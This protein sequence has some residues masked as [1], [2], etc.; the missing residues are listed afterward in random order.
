MRRSVKYNI[1]FMLCCLLWF[2]QGSAEEQTQEQI[3]VTDL[4]EDFKEDPRGPYQAI[5]WFCPDG[6][7]IPAQERCDQPGGIQHALHKDVA[8]KLAEEHG[9]YLGQ[10][11]AGTDFEEF[12][13]AANR[14]SRAKQYQMEQFLQAV[15][16]G[17]IMRKARYYRGAVQVEDEEAWGREFLTWLVARDDVLQS[18]F[19]LIR[20]LVK[21]IPHQANNDRATLIRALSQTIADSLDLFM[22]IR[23]KIHAKPDE[24]D[25]AKVREFRKVYAETFTPGIDKQLLHLEHQLRA[26]YKEANLASLQGYL[27]TFPI[28]TPVGAQLNNVLKYHADSESGGAPARNGFDGVKNK[29]K[30]CEEIAKL[31][32]ILRTNLSKESSPENRLL[33]LDLSLEAESIV[34]KNINQYKPETVEG[35]LHKGYIL[36]KA[37]AG[38]GYVEEWEW[39]NIEPI[40]L[41][42]KTTEALRFERF[43]E[44]ASS[45]RREVDWGTSMVRA[46]YEPVV[47]LFAEFEPL[48]HG[49][50]DDRIRSSVL[51]PFGEVCGQLLEFA[52]SKSGLR[53]QV[54]DV[55]Q[56]TQV[57]GLNPGFAV[58]V[59][60]VIEGT[61]EKID[62]STEKIYVIQR[63]P[64]E[65]K[66]V[67][68]IATVTEGNTVSHVQLLARNLGIPNAVVSSE[69]LHQ[70][71]KYTQTEVFYAVS[72]R[73]SV[74]MKP[75]GEMTE[76]ERTLVTEKQRSE[77]RV[78]VPTEK[79]DLEQREIISLFDLRARH[80]G[81]ICGPKAANL[82]QLSAMFPGKVVPG[83]VLPFGIFRAHLD[84]PMPG[85]DITYWD[86]LQQAFA[87]AEKQHKQ[88]VAEDRIE[89]QLLQHFETFRNAIEEIPF[90]P[91]FVAELKQRFEQEFKAEMG[92]LPIFIRSDTNM[93]DL[94]DFVG[95]G[96]NK[97]AINIL[98]E[99]EILSSIK[100]VWASPYSDRSFRWRQK[101]L[102][103]P[104][105]V[106]PSL[107][108]MPS[109]NVEKSGV[110]ITTGIETGNAHDITVAMNW[111][112][113][114]A[115]MGQTTET[116]LFKEDGT[117]ILLSPAR[118]TTYNYLP[119]KGGISQPTVTFEK[120]I[121]NSAERQKL[122][123]FAEELKQKLPRT[124]GIETEGP[125]DVE[126]GFWNDQ[127]WLFQVRPFV[128]N[129]LAQSSAYLTSLDP[130]RPENLKIKLTEKM[131]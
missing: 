40:L 46:I 10:I 68:G 72:P 99:E 102:L 100:E 80:S 122:R 111:G 21:D 11:L 73:G 131:E 12:W 98:Q 114:G 39:L 113:A 87:E 124:P 16:N 78:M 120:P 104:E 84:Q 35:L 47:A 127:I 62:F 48:A 50:I 89:N 22:D 34:F 30:M 53:N 75:V 60:E 108:L 109:V 20:Q 69:V 31:L 130:A 3:K 38:C 25:L 8:M 82:G 33:M 67:A 37:A 57:R 90:L 42:S 81:S 29:G 88:G 2:G 51:L 128:E 66:P 76:V 64:S 70:L 5:R 79:L 14:H 96:L 71:E 6:S 129:K 7:V 105:N 106:F 83:L 126:L 94:K 123:L 26:Y 44:I 9:I 125:F 23:V 103:N 24:T 65:M 36:A 28:H 13:D 91:G 110:M 101:Y 32:W 59:L 55:K 77:E 41:R 97:S 112:G 121:L 85:K 18:H 86:F 56:Q 115:V 19:F 95:A 116:Y 93:E 52:N 1:C 117:D 27:D 54:M 118:E 49:F 63:P 92:H 15:D 61:P 45:L 119:F 43:L 74:V 58:G 4:V 107:L 17:W